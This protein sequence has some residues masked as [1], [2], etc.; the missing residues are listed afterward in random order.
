MSFDVREYGRIKANPEELGSFVSVDKK[1]Y[2]GTEPG[3]DSVTTSGFSGAV[4]NIVFEGNTLTLENPITVDSD[5]DAVLLQAEIVKALTTN[6][7][8]EEFQP[9][10]KVTNASGDD[11]TV[12]HIGVGTLSAVGGEATTRKTTII[13]ATNYTGSFV[14]TLGVVSVNGAAGTALANDPYAWSGTPATDNATAA[15]LAT[16]LG[17]ALTAQGF[18]Y[19]SIAVSANTTDSDYD[20]TVYGRKSQKIT[21]GGTALSEA[22]GSAQEFV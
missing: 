6:G 10:V 20:V 2:Y 15:Q 5:A 16:D 19:K 22:T 12:E 14:A 21:I 18:D 17:L 4:S 11:F 9:W 1:E 8:V 7:I 13:N 3:Y